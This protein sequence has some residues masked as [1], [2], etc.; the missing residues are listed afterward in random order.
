MQLAVSALWDDVMGPFAQTWLPS[1]LTT[2]MAN[3][4]VIN[5]DNIARQVGSKEF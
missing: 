3:Y 5:T 1:V 2:D 4:L